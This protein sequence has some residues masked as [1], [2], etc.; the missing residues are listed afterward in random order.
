MQ[1]NNPSNYVLLKELQYQNADYLEKILH[2]IAELN[3]NIM[4]QNAETL[5]LLK[6]TTD[7]GSLLF[8]YG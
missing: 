4:T 7:E 5:E 8:A 6:K 3:K 1:N 2:E